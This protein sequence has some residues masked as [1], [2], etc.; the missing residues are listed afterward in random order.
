M[1]GRLWLVEEVWCL[2]QALSV[3]EQTLTMAFVQLSQEPGN[4][5]YTVNTFFIYNVTFG[6]RAKAESCLVCFYRGKQ[7][8]D[9]AFSLL[10][11]AP[12]AMSLTKQVQ[13]SQENLTRKQSVGYKHT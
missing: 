9:G 3:A 4:K 8:E 6:W 2:C 12:I 5:S 13:R 10:L 1:V 7:L 11:A